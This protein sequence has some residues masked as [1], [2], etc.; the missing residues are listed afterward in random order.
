M[1]NGVIYCLLLVITVSCTNETKKIKSSIVTGSGFLPLH[2]SLTA[3]PISLF[4]TDNIYKLFY[5]YQGSRQSNVNNYVS[6]MGS[7]ISTDL[8][9]WRIQS[10]GFSEKNNVVYK[11]GITKD[12]NNITGFGSKENPP[13][14]A[15]LI[16]SDNTNADTVRGRNHPVL[17]YSNDNGISWTITENGINF[18]ETFI[19]YPQNVNIF[20]HETSA[21]WIMSLGLS[22]SI[23]LYSSEDLF[24]W[25]FESSNVF[26]FFQGDLFIN[27]TCLVPLEDGTHWALFLDIESVEY[28]QRFEG[29]VYMIGFFNGHGFTNISAK[30]YLL[31]YGNNIHGG[32]VSV[33]S[34][35]T[36]IILLW[37]DN[38]LENSMFGSSQKN[39]LILLPRKIGSSYNENNEIILSMSP[40]DE[41]RNYYGRLIKKE[42]VNISEKKNK[43]LSYI[44]PPFVAN[45]I[46]NT[47]KIKRWNFPSRFG[48]ILSNDLSENITIGYDTPFRNYFIINTI[49]N[50]SRGTTPESLNMPFNYSDSTMLIKLYVDNSRVE[51]YADNDLLVMTSCYSVGKRFNKLTL[52]SENGTLDLLE[53]EISNLKFR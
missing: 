34:N 46:F 32:I 53:C 8:V 18:P 48:L 38:Y 12:I 10:S 39:S 20:W 33:G 1:K 22:N 29:I 26:D 41:L 15:L 50:K 49:K 40:I 3:E 23:L 4:Y 11:G 44:K 36:T 37:K 2:N 16:I 7:T 52:F 45:F 27:C 28:E 14:I 17:A 25:N 47:S 13:L 19:N 6:N 5:I 43:V 24:S 35:N 31:D 42:S 9:K 51:L 30:P 21:K